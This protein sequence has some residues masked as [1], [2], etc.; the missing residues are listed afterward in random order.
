MSFVDIKNPEWSSWAHELLVNTSSVDLDEELAA[1][2][3]TY[4]QNDEKL[5]DEFFLGDGNLSEE[6]Y[7]AKKK[8][9][10]AQLEKDK[11]EVERR[12]S[13]N[14][15]GKGK[16]KERA[17]SMTRSESPVASGANDKV[18]E[19][20]VT[21][22]NERGTTV[23][24]DESRQLVRFVKNP[25]VEREDTPVAQSSTTTTTFDWTKQ[26]P[27]DLCRRTKIECKFNAGEKNCQNC[28]PRKQACK[29]NGVNRKGQPPKPRETK[30][31]KARKAK[32]GKDTSEAPTVASSPA[33]SV[34]RKRAE[35]A[36]VL[37]SDDGD[38]EDQGGAQ[39]EEGEEGT[40]D[41]TVRPSKSKCSFLRC[42]SLTSLF[43]SRGTRLRW[44]ASASLRAAACSRR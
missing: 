30:A 23:D 37:D 6:E 17:R 28:E 29:W 3:A 15:K 20:S 11:E 36:I 24:V 41:D 32:K 7:D 40:V 34:K 31:K 13:A 16:E 19:G 35:K 43:Y 5:D 22:E 10:K 25:Q 4:K 9:L 8:E 44:Q 33:A 12:A 27:C 21:A 2:E 14:A 26:G 39:A 42:F 38:A 1:L 18:D